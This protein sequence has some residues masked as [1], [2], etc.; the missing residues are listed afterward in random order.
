MFTDYFLI[1]HI[2][3]SFFFIKLK[4]DFDYFQIIFKRPYTP[5]ILLKFI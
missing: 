3:V 5:Y 1:F 2:K 4:I